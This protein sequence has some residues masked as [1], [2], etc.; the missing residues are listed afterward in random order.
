MRASAAVLNAV[1]DALAPFGAEVARFPLN[2]E[3]ILSA[4]AAAKGENKKVRPALFRY[5]RPKS[6]E[7]ALELKAQYGDEASLLAGGKVSCRCSI[8]GW[9][10][11][12]C[13]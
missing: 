8:C 9:H 7:E 12:P 10:A 13:D 5:R 2:P 1:N 6:L 3:T 4:L 11:R